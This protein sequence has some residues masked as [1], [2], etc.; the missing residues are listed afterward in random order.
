MA[1]R[2]PIARRWCALLLILVAPASGVPVSPAPRPP[3]VGLALSADILH[4]YRSLASTGTPTI[5]GAGVRSFQEP[6]SETAGS[7]RFDIRWVAHPPGLPPG[8]IIQLE[9]IQARSPAVQ[10]QVVGLAR[11]TAGV[12]HTTLEIPARQIQ[13]AGRVH[14]WRISIAWRGHILARQ[15]SPNWPQL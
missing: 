5:P 15:S 14:A 7:E 9:A 4:V 3:S 2:S 12:T 1:A 6:A 8:A 10:N 11:R 13:R